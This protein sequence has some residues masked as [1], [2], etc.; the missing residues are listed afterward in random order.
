[1]SAL[2]VVV[3]RRRAIWRGAVADLRNRYAGSGLGLFWNLLHPLA[4]IA[5]YTLV[6]GVLMP[7][8]GRQGPGGFVLFLCA[9]ILPWLSFA[10]C[11]QRTTSAFITHATDLKKLAVPELVYWAQETVAVALNLAISFALFVPI[12]CW[13]GATFTWCW[14]CLPLLLGLW[15]VFAAG[16]G[17]ALCT[18]NVFFRDVA[19]IVT[20]CLPLWMWL[21]PVVYEAERIPGALH[22]WLALNPVH[23]FVEAVRSV[24]IAGQMP[25][26]GPWFAMLTVSA[27]SLVAGYLVFSC[28]RTQIRDQL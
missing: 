6:F 27:L 7:M 11:V 25:G 5:T 9:G 10:E 13:L 14:L 17:L 24:L 26:P 8:P 20:V 3:Q 2:A 21:T 22:A 1:M 16:L 19:Q 12:A 4:Q 23:A 15:L 18:V 28:L